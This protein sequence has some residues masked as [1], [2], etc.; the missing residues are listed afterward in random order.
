MGNVK[1]ERESI[2]GTLVLHQL[3]INERN[4][5][6]TINGNINGNQILL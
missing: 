5:K 2:S 3:L 1:R 6:N 4:V